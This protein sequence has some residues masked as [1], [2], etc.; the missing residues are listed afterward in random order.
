MRTKRSF[1]V[2]FEKKAEKVGLGR[3]ILKWIKNPAAA[4]RGLKKTNRYNL[5]RLGLGVGIPLTGTA[6]LAHRVLGE[7]PSNVQPLKLQQTPNYY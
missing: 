7:S 5:S 4:E 6:Y 1:I 2:G 3:R